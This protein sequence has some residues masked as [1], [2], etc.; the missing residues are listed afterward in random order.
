MQGTT[1]TVQLS[2]FE[3]MSLL[4]G[5]PASCPNPNMKY[6]CNWKGNLHKIKEHLKQCESENELKRNTW[7]LNY[8]QRKYIHIPTEMGNMI[9]LYSMDKTLEVKTLQIVSRICCMCESSKSSILC[10]PCGHVST[11]QDCQ[12]S[13]QLNICIYCCRGT[14]FIKTLP[15]LMISLV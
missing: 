15:K 2:H 5:K 1:K 8:W 4:I 14:I 11:C 7:I 12:E 10:V 9:T 13:E 3:R 6:I